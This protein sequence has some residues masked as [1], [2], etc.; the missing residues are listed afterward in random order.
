MAE[1]GGYEKQKYVFHEMEMQPMN[2]IRTNKISEW[3][4]FR[5]LSHQ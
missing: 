3:D 5:K 4:N 2:T 1:L